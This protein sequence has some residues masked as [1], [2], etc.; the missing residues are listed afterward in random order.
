MNRD[1][2]TRRETEERSHTAA[3]NITSQEQAP[4]APADSPPP[5]SAGTDLS[6]GANDPTGYGGASSPYVRARGA[7]ADEESDPTSPGEGDS[8]ASSSQEHL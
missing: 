1:E 3:P 4:R 2:E 8:P 7:D 6:A 5:A